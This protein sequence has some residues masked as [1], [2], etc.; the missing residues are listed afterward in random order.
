MTMDYGGSY[1]QDM[2]NYAIQAAN[3]VANQIKQIVPSMSNTDIMKLIGLIPMIG[4]NDI[5]TE[6]FTLEDAQQVAS[7]VRKNRL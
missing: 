3:S 7:Y 6:N 2:G 1:N 4:L 5:T